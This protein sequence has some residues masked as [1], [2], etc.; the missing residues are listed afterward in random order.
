[1]GKLYICCCRRVI[2]DFI[3]QKVDGEGGSYVTLAEN[4]RR[5]QNSLLLTL[6][7]PD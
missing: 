1:M 2:A 7:L 6:R 5:M 4:D 3:E